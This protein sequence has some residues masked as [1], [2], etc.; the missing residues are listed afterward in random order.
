MPLRERVAQLI[1]TV[2]LAAGE[3]ECLLL[4]STLVRG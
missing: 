3:K 4:M 2:R 1:G